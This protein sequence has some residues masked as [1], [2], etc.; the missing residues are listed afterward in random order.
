MSHRL[1]ALRQQLAQAQQLFPGLLEACFE[2]T[3]LL[4]GSLYALRRKC[5][6]KACRCTRGQLHEST[7]LS[8]RGQGRAQNII[9]ASEHLD[10]LRAMTQ[11]YRQCRQARVQLRRWFANLLQLLDALQTER[12]QLGNAQ[13]HKLRAAPARKSSPSRS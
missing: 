1:S 7:V 6:K 10:A 4:P 3:P 2:R 8:Y 9:P 12:V 11:H 5:G 13:F